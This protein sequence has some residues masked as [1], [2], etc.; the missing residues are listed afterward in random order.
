MVLLI[1]YDTISVVV[2]TSFDWMRFAFIK[3]IRGVNFNER[4]FP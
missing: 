1:G 3:L 2:N 4:E